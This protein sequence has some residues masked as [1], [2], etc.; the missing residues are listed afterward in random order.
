MHTVTVFIL[1]KMLSLPLEEENEENE[2]Q[3]I[4]LYKT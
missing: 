1:K 2:V 4:K 3:N